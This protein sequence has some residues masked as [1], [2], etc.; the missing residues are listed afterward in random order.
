MGISVVYEQLGV[1]FMHSFEHDHACG[2]FNSSENFYQNII[3]I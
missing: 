3:S 2:V 1:S